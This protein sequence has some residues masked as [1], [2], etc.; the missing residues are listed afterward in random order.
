MDNTILI[1]VAVVAAAVILKLPIG[2]AGRYQIAGTQSGVFRVDTAT[3]DTWRWF[4]ADGWRLAT[5]GSTP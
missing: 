1:A 2:S 4:T 5:N 3:G